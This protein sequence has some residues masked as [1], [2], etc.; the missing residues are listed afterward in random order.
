[1]TERQRQH[2]L[3]YYVQS[4]APQTAIRPHLDRID[5]LETLAEDGLVSE[6]TIHVVGSGFVH[7]GNYDSVPIAQRLKQ[8]LA[9]IDR[10][11]EDNDASLPGISTT[12]M[13]ETC[14]H[15]MAYTVTRVPRN[16]LLEY[17]GGDLRF[18]SP[19]VVEGEHVSVDDH[20]ADIR[21]SEERSN[22]PDVARVR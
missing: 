12:T 4:L 16:M 9:E 18:C 21:S 17:V 10:W 5:Q 6:Y 13:S 8:R 20:L 1:M 7:E 15:D 14:F 22:R 2:S 3:E 11:A 19:A